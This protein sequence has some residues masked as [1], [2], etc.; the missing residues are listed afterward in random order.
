[1]KTRDKLTLGLLVAMSFFLMCDLFI[2]PA[3]IS[4][5][6]AEYSVTETALGWVGSAFILVGAGISVFFGYQTDKVSRKKLLI[7][8]AFAG[9]IPCLLTGFHFFT[10]TFQGFLAMRILTGIGIGGMYPITFSLVGDYFE[11]RHRATASAFIDLAWGVGM[12]IGPFLAGY[13]LTTEYGWR[14]AFILAALPNFPIILIFALVAR[15]PERGGSEKE[16]AHA[17]K[18]GAHYNHRIQFRDFLLIF[19]NRTNLFLFLQGI[20]GTIPWGLFPFWMISFYKATRGFSQAE[21]TY[22]WQFFGISAGLGG[23]A[24]AMLGDKLFA[25]RPSYLPMLCTAGI[26]AGTIPCFMIL[27]IELPSLNV[28]LALAAL[29]GILVSVPSSNNKAILLNVNRPEHRGSVFS[30]FNISDNIGKGI[31]PAIGGMVLALTG[32]DSF[33]ANFALSFWLLCGLL[34]FFVI[35]SI[36]KDRT[37]LVDLMQSRAR[38][39]KK[40]EEPDLRE[41]VTL[42]ARK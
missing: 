33:M 6:A 30:V 24:W 3:I 11:E 16:L 38:E 42:G 7:I 31:G 13:A 32:S 12:A 5:L 25:K 39:L 17:I 23:F 41:T 22:I 20:P 9:E 26:F 4:N 10:D 21:A 36:N 28:Y 15:D 27:N 2:T 35:R 29:T 19:K 34:F 1:M 40:N 8:T 37:N 14:L 18:E